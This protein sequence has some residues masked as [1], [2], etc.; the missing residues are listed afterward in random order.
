MNSGGV[1]VG[2]NGHTLYS[3]TADTPAHLIC[4]GSCLTIWPPVLGTAKAGAGVAA[5]DLGT[6]HRGTAVQVTYK[7]HPLYEFKSDMAAGDERG[8]GLTDQGGTWHPAAAAASSAP[9]SPSHGGGYG[10]P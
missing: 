10:Y 2:P 5:A 7:G 1:L 3:N 4:T 8:A 9:S 6:V